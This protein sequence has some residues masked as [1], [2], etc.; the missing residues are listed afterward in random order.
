MLTA[1]GISGPASSCAAGTASAG[2][3]SRACRWPRSPRIYAGEFEARWRGDRAVEAADRVGHQRAE[4]IAP[5]RVHVPGRT[6]RSRAG[7]GPR[8]A[9]HRSGPPARRPALRGRRARR[10]WGRRGCAGGARLPAWLR[11]AL[12]ISRETGMA[13][14]GPALLGWLAL[15]TDDAD[16]RR[17]ALAEAEALLAAGSVSHNYIFF[18]HAA[19][20]AALVRRVARRRAL[21]RGARGLHPRR[22]AAVGRVRHRARPGARRLGP[23]RRD[24]TAVERLRG[25]R[26]HAERPVCAMRLRCARGGA[27]ARPHDSGF[28]LKRLKSEPCAS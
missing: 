11:E 2:S 28:G 12:A 3:R 24:A 21:R 20:E 5:H 10:S 13:F 25:L 7:A 15:I 23:G 18:Y 26:A 8:R 16:E 14:I 27:R 6:R 4:M 22:T 1:G 19:I 17:A 9:R